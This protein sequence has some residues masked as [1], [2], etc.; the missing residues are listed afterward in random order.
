MGTLFCQYYPKAT[1]LKIVHVLFLSLSFLGAEHLLVKVG[2]A[3]YSHW[4]IWGS[5][6]MNIVAFCTLG[7]VTEIL[8][9]NIPKSNV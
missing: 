1:W 2:V 5:L 9:L 8:K 6:F 7:W 3:S 4:N